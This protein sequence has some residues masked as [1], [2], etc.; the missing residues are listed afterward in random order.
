MPTEANHF[1]ESGSGNNESEPDLKSLYDQL[2]TSSSAS[3]TYGFHL[4]KTTKES[5]LVHFKSLPL[6]VRSRT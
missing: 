3:I 6:D 4:S 1:I 5:T 2:C